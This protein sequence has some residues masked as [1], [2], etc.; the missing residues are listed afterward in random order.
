ML[1]VLVTPARLRA[2]YTMLLAF[3]PF[4]R[5]D[6]PKPETI[7]F[8]LLAD[9]DHGEYSI[10]EKDRVCIAVNPDTHLTLLQVCES[11]A[12]EMCHVRQDAK[13]RLPD[14]EAKHHNTEFRRLA[15]LVCRN[16]GFDV[17]RF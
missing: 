12:H 15:R 1:P 14:I 16:L 7:K 3:P 4:N 6:M 13:G 10:N 9:A 17:Q 8:E 5:W 2:V 11:V